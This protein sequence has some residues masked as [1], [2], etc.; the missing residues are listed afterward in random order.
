[1]PQLDVMVA[2]AAVLV[3][4]DDTKNSA[5]SLSPTLPPAT[6]SE[7]TAPKAVHDALASYT[8]RK[9]LATYKIQYTASLASITGVDVST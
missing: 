5:W 1:M 7:M 6:S 9:R 8:N 3:A 4:G 2:R